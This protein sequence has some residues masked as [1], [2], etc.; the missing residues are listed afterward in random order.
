MAYCRFEKGVSD[1]YLYL[2]CDG[3]F[4]CSGCNIQN[5]DVR[6]HKTEEVIMHLNA[7]QRNGH[8][9]PE[10]AFTGLERD[11]AK[12]DEWIQQRIKQRGRSF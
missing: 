1:V 10:Y 6:F 11:R 12:N 9:V 3:H 7:H 8:L 2:H 4:E 5:V